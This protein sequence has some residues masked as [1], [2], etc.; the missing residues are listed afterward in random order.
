MTKAELVRKI[1]KRNGVPDS[2]ATIFFEIFLQKAS[3]LLQPA[4]A[5]RLKGFGYFQ[6]KQAVIKTS[7]AKISNPA[8]TDIIVYTPSI[9]VEGHEELIFNIPSQNIEKYNIVDSYFSL[10]FGKM[11]IPLQGVKDTDFFIPP[12]G[13]ELKKLIESKVNKLLNESEIITEHV[14]GGEILNYKIAGSDEDQLEINW[15]RNKIEDGYSKEKNK[16]KEIGEES[17]FGHIAWDFGDDLSKQIEE[18][19][20]LDTSTETS[21]LSSFEPEGETDSLKWDIGNSNNIEDK[22]KNIESEERQK[23]YSSENKF[24]QENFTT[25]EFDERV[26]DELK[27]FERV[28]SITSEFVPEE[29]KPGLTKSEMDLSW[30]FGETEIHSETIGHNK[31]E[32]DETELS[33]ITSDKSDHSIIETN[34]D[35]RIKYDNDLLIDDR[36]N[37][38]IKNISPSKDLSS[39]TRTREYSYSRKRSPFVFFIAMVTIITVSAAVFFYI[40]KTNFISFTNKILNKK[41]KVIRTFPAEIIDRSFDVP[42]TYPY[43]KKALQN[44]S[45]NEITPDAVNK[46]KNSAS[47]QPVQ[48]KNN[49]SDLLNGKKS[50]SVDKKSPAPSSHENNKNSQSISNYIKVKENIFKQ[51][52]NYLVQASS[53]RSKSI[54]DA[55]AEKFRKKGYN[56]YLEKAEL[57]GRGIWY[58][59]KVGNFKTLTDAEN[60]LKT[61]K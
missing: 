5:L 36:E 1:A 52:E 18:E 26:A 8:Y 13:F 38:K 11:V 37:Q 55:E 10:S 47:S 15:D 34:E 49:L 2:E 48:Q 29:I 27:N 21:L 14:K 53:W 20:I 57:P 30:N 43:P 51:N 3:S 41:E 42:V 12:T 39:E 19:S 31:K 54:A 46:G 56:S 44:N 60:F 7:S 22:N 35:P 9:E 33:E 25:Q 50:N 17:E 58:R 4:Q 6:L 40:T 24:E 59:I 28:K 32:L 16:Y 45:S 23:K 61:N